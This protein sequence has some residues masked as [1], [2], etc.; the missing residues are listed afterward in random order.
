MKCGKY[1][2]RNSVLLDYFIVALQNK[3]Q[4]CG[5]QQR[6]VPLSFEVLVQGSCF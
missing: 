2:V 6:I 1:C 4:T 5:L 3:L